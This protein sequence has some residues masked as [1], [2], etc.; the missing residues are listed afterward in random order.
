MRRQPGRSCRV[1]GQFWDRSTGGLRLVVVCWA[2]LSGVVCRVCIEQMPMV[3]DVSKNGTDSLRE[4]SGRC[5]LLP[6][7]LVA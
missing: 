2:Q 4:G 7:G 6:E 3:L 5:E 1:Q